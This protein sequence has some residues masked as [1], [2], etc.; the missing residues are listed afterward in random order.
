MGIN[1]LYRHRLGKV[2]NLT[3]HVGLIIFKVQIG[4]SED[5]K[6]LSFTI[7]CTKARFQ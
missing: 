6:E 4:F 1:F 5:A 3:A 7:C 2:Q